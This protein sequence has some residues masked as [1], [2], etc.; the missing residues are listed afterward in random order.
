MTIK[1]VAENLSKVFGDDPG[2][3]LD[4]VQDGK[5]KDESNRMC[6][7]IPNITATHYQ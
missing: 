1:I 2:Q 3:A 5:T 4:L 7:Y 6:T